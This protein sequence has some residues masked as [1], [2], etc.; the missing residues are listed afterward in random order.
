[1]PAIYP[2]RVVLSDG[3]TFTS[4]TTAPTPSILRLTRDVT[5][6]PLWAPGTEKRG[7][8]DGVEEGRVGRFRRRFEG[9]AGVGLETSEGASAGAGAGAKKPDGGMAFGEADFE[10]MSEGAKEEKVSAKEMQ[11]KPKAGAKKR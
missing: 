11:G 8:G 9:T 1:M 10:W 4:Y 3:S 2:Q 6:N 5:N 7:L